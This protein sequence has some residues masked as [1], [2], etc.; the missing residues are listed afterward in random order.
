MDVQADNTLL[1]SE[2]MGQLCVFAW[3]RCRFN[4]D[5]WDHN[6]DCPVSLAA[7]FLGVW[8]LACFLFTPGIFNG[9]YFI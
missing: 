8:F 5:F 9:Y 1:A 4:T 7:V 6:L 2:M 3:S